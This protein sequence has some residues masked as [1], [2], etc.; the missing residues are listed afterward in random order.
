MEPAP[1]RYQ[2]RN[3][4]VHRLAF[5]LADASWPARGEK[6]EKRADYWLAILSALACK[7]ARGFSY[8]LA[9]AFGLSAAARLTS[10]LVQTLVFLQDGVDPVAF[11]TPAGVEGQHYLQQARCCSGSPLGRTVHLLFLAG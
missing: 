7:P 10:T 9:F 6:G 4:E 8:C 11:L 3:S 1:K 2:S 5:Y